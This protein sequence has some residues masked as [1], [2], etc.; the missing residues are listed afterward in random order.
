[1]AL[2]KKLIF[3]FLIALCCCLVSCTD[4][5][6]PVSDSDNDDD[7]ATDDDDNDND[8]DFDDPALSLARDL[9]KTWSQT[10]E[11][12]QNAWS[13][14]SG[15]MMMG[16]IAENQ[17]DILGEE[18]Q[19]YAK[20]WIDHYLETGFTVASSDTS[21]PG[22]I[23]L[24]LYQQT[25]EQKYLDAADRVWEYI[26]EKAGR[27]GDGGLNHMGWISG[28]QI[29]V[30]TLFMVG[31]FLLEYAEVTGL[32]EPYEEFAL[33]LEVFRRHL[34]DSDSGLYRHRYDDD[35]GEVLPDEPLYW[36]RGNGWA[37][38]ASV[39]ANNRLPD[40][41]KQNM[42]FDL[43]ADL[44]QMYAGIQGMQ[45]QGGRFHTILNRNDTYLET[46]A[47]LLY[48]YALCLDALGN[49]IFDD[50]IT[51]IEKWLQGAIEEIVVDQA[52]DTLILG[53]SCGT[54]PGG[55]EY[56]DQV[57]KVENVSYGL[58]L[59]LLTAMSREDIEGK[60]ELQP[61]DGNFSEDFIQPPS[62]CQGTECGKFHIA[63]GNYNEAQ[64]DFDSVI[65]SDSD[66]AEPRFYRALI[67]VIRL[68]TDFMSILDQV[69]IEDISISDALAWLADSGRQSAESISEDLQ[70][71]QLDEDFTSVLE[72]VLMIEAGGHSA[73]GEREYDLGEAYLLDALAHLLVGVTSLYSKAP[74]LSE[75][76]I[77][78]PRKWEQTLLSFPWK[79]VEESKAKG[80]KAGLSEIVTGL[81]KLLLAIDS[82]MAET[83]DQS[84]DIV[85][86]NLLALE[87][88][89][90]IP[91]VLPETDVLELLTGFGIPQWLLELL[92]MPEALVGL[93]ET[94]RNVLQFIIGI[95]P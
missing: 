59:F 12:S 88:T 69:Y 32:D 58:G 75:N 30:D 16:M 18:F 40:A 64:N 78:S 71:S 84:D 47:G 31:P 53:T 72:R 90:F 94:I 2:D 37:F 52:S 82:I 61:P 48:A 35:T 68:V 44:K 3:L 79:S 23:C 85:P 8:D 41:I 54:S 86:A 20:D 60:T 74:D 73:I 33:Q 19:A 70:V 89:F 56:Y 65:D 66:S 11:P 95:L 38:V 5:Q 51:W 10:Y 93:L 45:I 28:N 24:K 7:D 36:G 80:L 87:G 9:A 62:P 55:V 43:E 81:D 25:G 17:D 39:M 77:E 49:S 4:D 50:Q 92:D 27:T 1:M 46:S 26:S 83:D 6:E 21:I 63:R 13:W 22:K 42:E 14:D 34:R 76:L 67:R 91:G 29:W 15:V 57:L